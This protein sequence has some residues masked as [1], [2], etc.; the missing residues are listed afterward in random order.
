MMDQLNFE[1]LYQILE[2]WPLMPIPKSAVDGV[3]ERVRQIIGPSQVSGKL[4]SI[5]DLSVLL[6]QI[7]RRQSLQND[8]DAKLLVPRSPDWPDREDWAKYGVQT[9]VAKDKY[10]II[11]NSWFPSWVK[12]EDSPLFEGSYSERE[13]RLNWRRQI[14]DFLKESSGFDH[15]YSPGQREAVRSAL[16]TPDGETLIISLPTGS[17]KSLVSQA[18]ILARGL[19]GPLTICVVPT[20]SLALDQERQTNKMLQ[21]LRPGHK[22][23]N[24]SF[25]SGISEE[26]RRDIKLAIKNG[27]QGILYCSPEAVTNALLPALFS[28]AETGLLGYFIIDEAHLISQWGDGF[29]PAFQLL[30]GVRRALL[31][32]CS[33][34]KFKTILM[35]ATLTPETLHVIETLFGP[36][37]K[38]QMASSIYLRPEPQ[39][40]IHKENDAQIKLSKIIEALRHAP[41]PCIVYVT[42]RID[43]ENLVHEV[44]KLGFK[45]IEKF[46]GETQAADRRK[47]IDEWAADKI[48][49]M[50]ATSAFGVGIDKTDVR[51][52]IHST[53]PETLDRFYQEVG[54]GGRDGK[55]SSSLIIYSDDDLALANKLATSNILTEE[56]AFDRWIAMFDNGHSMDN[57]GISHKINIKSVPVH[58]RQQSDHNV[59]WNMRLLNM[60]V[61]AEMLTIEIE[62]PKVTFNDDTGSKNNLDE[63]YWDDYFTQLKVKILDPAHRNKK[64]FALRLKEERDRSIKASDFSQG[65][66][67]SLLSGTIEISIALQ[68][69][70]TS[71]KPGRTTIISRACGGCSFHRKEQQL[72]IKYSDAV[73]CGIKNVHAYETTIFKACFPNLNLNYPI[74]IE[75]PFD[76]VESQKIDV[77]STL[78][79]DF[80]IKEVAVPETFRQQ[81]QFK[82]LHRQSNDGL[83]LVQTI[84]DE[85]QHGYTIYNT[86]R[87]TLINTELH[88]DLLMIERPLHIILLPCDMLDPLNSNRR[89]RETGT[90][91]L[92]FEQFCASSQS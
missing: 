4:N 69:L 34:K 28:A 86:P 24:F 21:K 78:I 74:Y 87:V 15:Y 12:K 77:L 65:L 47:L 41:R 5:A 59:S 49:I 81:R 55:I 27:S 53:V 43:A 61:R 79:S 66:L 83:L 30:S 62:A 72:P 17:G 60:M 33:D 40:W 38:I 37:D 58:L 90:N 16:L 75:L 3:F 85:K 31:D 91:F 19:E 70:Y 51:S 6:R 73:A 11:A 89:I 82:S 50:V 25:H 23:S 29:R 71:N 68:K 64:M 52:V 56:L 39:Y 67:K 42:K 2:E 76:M 35:S 46:H 20:T 54:R 18:P 26:K 8:Q 84:E 22:W 57:L 14:D 32:K 10:L 88:E 48:D 44:R 45:R 80:G 1:R 63:E 7:L 13:V 36:P 92:S 9:I